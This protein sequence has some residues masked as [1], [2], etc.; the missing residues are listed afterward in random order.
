MPKYSDV[1]STVVVKIAPDGDRTQVTIEHHDVLP[2]WAG[3]TEQGWHDL[4][5]R[6]EDVL[7]S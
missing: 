3:R 5:R 1:E 6:L 2:E 7:G 4:L